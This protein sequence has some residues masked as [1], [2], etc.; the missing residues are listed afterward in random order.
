M[1]TDIFVKSAKPGM[2]ADDGG[3][4][5]RVSP[6]GK[7]VWV[8]RSPWRTLGVYPT[9][10]LA[11]ARAA[12]RSKETLTTADAIKEYVRKINVVRPKQVEWLMAEFPDIAADRKTLVDILQRKAKKSPVMANRMLSRW[13]DFLNY[14]LQQGWITDNV[15]APVQR[16]FIG[17][18][19]NSR[20][21]VLSWEE[22]AAITDPILRFAL[23]IGM[24]SSEALW[25]LKRKRTT[26]IPNKRTPKDGYLHDLPHSHLI[27][28]ALK[29][30]VVLPASHL[31]ISNRLRRN[32]ATF[33]P[34]DLR[35][36]FATRLSDLG[37]AP[38]IIEK[39]LGH[40]MQG[41]MAVYNRA[42]YW[43]ERVAAQRLWDRKLIRLWRSAA[44]SSPA[45]AESAGT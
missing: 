25:V 3:L 4:Y 39:L 30:K 20:D 10:G 36:T 26:G 28:Y 8:Q 43:P 14:A 9:M 40:K 35:R 29:Q 12:L 45:S 15:L 16:R 44:A 37:V 32:K 34:H 13:K 5:L 6:K 2:H 19:E 33:R 38:H 7:K 24:R 1:L 22:I 17:G 31:T 27:Q 23:L 11:S 42:E 41:V 18:K 21:R